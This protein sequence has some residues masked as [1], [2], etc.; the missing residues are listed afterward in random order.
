MIGLLIGSNFDLGG[1]VGCGMIPATMLIN[2]IGC[3]QSGKTTT[4]AMLFAALK[5]TGVIAEFSPEQ[6]RF[7]IAVMRLIF[8]ETGSETPFTLSDSDQLN[9]M[10][11][12][13]ENDEILVKACGPNVMI[14]S[15]SSPLNSML[16]MSPEFRASSEVQS[17]A[18]RALAL[19]PKTFYAC[20][21]YRPYLNDPNRVHTEAQ[22]HEIDLLIPGLLKEFPSLK[23]FPISGTITERLLQ[24]QNA[25]YYP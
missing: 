23:A 2:F 17:L 6:A 20:P 11:R 22:A 4:A 1:I 12:Q 25:I 5:E 24:V 9:I 16:Y 8:Q 7:Y 18:R 10:E 13:V 15:D 14:V 3:P 19:N 21:V